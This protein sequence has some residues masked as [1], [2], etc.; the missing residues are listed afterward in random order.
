MFQAA[1]SR[2]SVVKLR[3]AGKLAWVREAMLRRAPANFSRAMI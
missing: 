2:W 1:N 3:T